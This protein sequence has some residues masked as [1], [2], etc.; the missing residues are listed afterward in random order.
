MTKKNTKTPENPCV[1]KN[2][3]CKYLVINGTRYRTLYNSKFQNRKKWVAPDPTK[4]LSYIPGTIID[5]F[6]KEGQEIKQG[7]PLVTLEAMKMK[8]VITAHADGK[9]T[10]LNVKTGDRIPK[11]H[12]LVQLSYP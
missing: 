5:V 8:N 1:N 2:I 7:D 10:K 9:I 4:I 12:L 3:R 6:V 11:G